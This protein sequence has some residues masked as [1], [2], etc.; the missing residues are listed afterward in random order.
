MNDRDFEILAHA[1]VF[2]IARHRGGGSIIA[3]RVATDA[4]QATAARRA[5]ALGY[6]EA[7][8]S[9]SSV[10]VY[11]LTDAG[12][13]AIR[14]WER[15][16]PLTAEAAR[17]MP[18]SDLQSIWAGDPFADEQMRLRASGR[19]AVLGALLAC[20]ERH[21]ATGGWHVIACA[22]PEGRIGWVDTAK[23]RAYLSTAALSAEEVVALTVP[24][25]REGAVASGAV[26]VDAR[27]AGSG[28]VETPDSWHQLLVDVRVM[29]TDDAA[30]E[31]V[32]AELVCYGLV[33]C[34]SHRGAPAAGTWERWGE[35]VD[36]GL[37]GRVRSLARIR[38]EAIRDSLGEDPGYG[39]RSEAWE[40]AEV[41][42]TAFGRPDRLLREAGVAQLEEIARTHAAHG[43]RV[44]DACARI[45]SARLARALAPVAESLGDVSGGH[46]GS[47]MA[48]GRRREILGHV[49][50]GHGEAI[51]REASDAARAATAECVEALY[52]A[53]AIV[54]AAG[55]KHG[56][57]C[58][59]PPTRPV[60]E[61]RTLD[62]C[63]VAY[64]PHGA[65][66]PDGYEHTL[67]LG[68][69]YSVC[70]RPEDAERLLPMLLD[71]RLPGR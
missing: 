59:R 16:V 57:T 56:V 12:R 53:G 26:H 1:R 62:G 47:P 6:V 35:E 7:R 18:L 10:L 25:Q 19:R 17:A 28:R 8:L 51:L 55:R 21:T 29:G 13:A 39:D 5:L 70:C 68:V 61:L 32:T 23:G 20:G 69:D 44:I 71:I 65:A 4:R 34:Y 52:S 27:T 46:P 15:R 40:V 41:C 14:A 2:S 48:K 50:D 9:P 67:E 37:Q 49:A 3:G 30:S 63:E 11:R 43:A 60:A 64:V 31:G 54:T 24:E 45:L 58:T 42:A 36:E 22:T 33:T 38:L 66:R